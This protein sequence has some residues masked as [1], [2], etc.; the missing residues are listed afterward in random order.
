MPYIKIQLKKDLIQAMK[1]NRKVAL[2]FS[3]KRQGRFVRIDSLE[4]ESDTTQLVY[5][6]GLDFPVL[7]VSPVFKNKEAR[8]GILYLVFRFF[9]YL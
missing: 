3:V 2:S 9:R 5:L 1:S 8:S 7:L 4:L 6:K